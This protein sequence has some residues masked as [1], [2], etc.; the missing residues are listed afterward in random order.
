MD[1]TSPYYG[2]VRLLTRILPLVAVE[3]SFALKGGTAINLFVRDL[4]RLSVDIDLV[5]LPMDDRDTALKNVAEALARIA[6]AIS[7]AMP[8][9]EIIRSFEQQADALRLFISQG[10]DRIKIELSPVL[11]GS[12]LPEELREVSPAVEEQ[13]GYVEMQLLSFPDLYAGKICAALDRQHPR[14]LFDV[15]LLLESEGLT[16]D[17]VRTFLAYLISHN[18]TMAEL[19]QPTRKNIAGIYEGEFVR[20]SQ[21]EVSLDELLT[22]RERLVSDLNRALT[23]NQRKFLISFKANRPDW[24]LLDVVGADRLPAVRWK[25]HNL[26]RMP[27]ERQRAAYDNLERVLGLGSS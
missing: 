18:R 4:P 2:Q 8:G 25:L 5:Y 1:S 14:D 27:R 3:K 10:A 6:D 16:E 20:M 12:V 7:A 9:T 22:V 19:L 13:F 26:E 15:K 23:D 17:L 21:V 11:R 24:S